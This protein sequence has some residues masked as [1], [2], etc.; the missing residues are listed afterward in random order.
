MTNVSQF[1]NSQYALKKSGP[2]NGYSSVLP[3]GQVLEIA[4]SR[5]AVIVAT[6]LS[7][8]FAH[9]AFMNALCSF[10]ASV[11]ANAL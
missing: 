8:I 2:L 10:Q 9:A 3:R 7:F 11:S 1:G 5:H 4:V 6:C